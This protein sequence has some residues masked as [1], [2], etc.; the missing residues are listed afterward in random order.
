MGDYEPLQLRSLSTI[1]EIGADDWD[2]CANPKASGFTTDI[3]DN[4]FLFHRFLKSLEESGCASTQTGWRPS[5]LAL[6]GNDGTL[7]GVMP[8]YVK[9]HSYGEYVFDHAWAEALERA[10]GRYY[11][12]LQCAIP[13]T[14]ATGRR[15][16]AK[17]GPQAQAVEQALA[18]G[19]KQV[20]HRL[21][22]S[23]LHITFCPKPQWEMLGAQGFLLRTDQQ[24]HWP[25]RGYESFEDF[26]NSLSSRKRKAIKRERA[27]AL[28]NGITVEWVTGNDISEAHWD[29][30]FEFYL[31]T[32]SRKWGRPYLNRLF[33]SLIGSRMKDEILLIMC[34]R[35]GRYIAGALNFIG[36][37]TLFGRY[38]GAVEHQ[39]FLHFEAC[40]YQAIDF[41]IE[42]R[43]DCVEAGAQGGHKIARGYLP[44]QTYSAHYVTEPSFHDALARYLDAERAHV[45]AGIEELANHAPYR[46]D[47]EGRSG[48][49]E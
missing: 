39:P 21:G 40:Y 29:A 34:K 9:S 1:T 8:L 13:F 43:L 32:G 12:K 35:D 4:P 27:E 49:D 5:H 16:L 45:D 37:D 6:E 25:N 22:L 17:P 46:K 3:A 10:G 33:F 19:A 42:R 24:F 23:S 48:D 11:P 14:P 44:S 30:F 36:S 20:L 28:Q 38:W 41:A 18:H 7:L 31:D 26:L 47:A 15:L 2:A